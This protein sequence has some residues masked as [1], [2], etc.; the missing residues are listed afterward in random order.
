LRG[1]GESG[2]LAPLRERNFA[3]LWTASAVSLL[4]DGV[5]TVAMTLAVLAVSDS[6]TAL[7]IVGA[8]WMAPQLVFLLLGGVVTDRVSPRTVLTAAEALRAVAVAVM[9]GLALGGD[10]TIPRIVVLT[11]VHGTG[12][13]FFAP[14]FSAV[15][16]MVCSKERLLQANVLQQ[17]SRPVAL[18]FAGPAL[19]GVLIAAG[20][21]ALP[22]GLDAASYVVSAGLIA[23]M[24]IAAQRRP[25]ERRSLREDLTAGLRYTWS[26]PWLRRSVGAAAIGLVTYLGPVTVL[27]PFLVEDELGGTA[28]ELGL[29]L[30]ASGA[31]SILGLLLLNRFRAR[32]RPLRFVYGAWAL[33]AALMA[34]NAAADAIWQ[35]A[36]AGAL[37]GGLSTTGA[38]VWSTWLQTE[39]PG[40]LLG[41]VASLD[42]LVSTSLVPASLLAVGPVAAQLGTRTTMWLGG[43]LAAVT[44]AATAVS[45]RD[46]RDSMPAPERAS[47]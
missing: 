7:G 44:F 26:T 10:L 17:V 27:L 18:R 39:V 31:G 28:K 23:C 32:S 12:E 40:H 16:P 37:V 4:G 36:L 45:F 41:R 9:T 14:A 3:L 6:P 30:A 21:V 20:G 46:R 33:A 13:A 47:A 5:Y 22:L 24:R 15:I 38:A 34:A 2:L 11:A 29:V 43:M 35:V 19:G 42:F 1:L 8:A 25:H